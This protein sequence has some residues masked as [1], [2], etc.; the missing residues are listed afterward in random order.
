MELIAQFCATAWR[1]GNGYEQPLNF[2]IEDH[3]FEL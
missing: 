3:W 1:N 2:N